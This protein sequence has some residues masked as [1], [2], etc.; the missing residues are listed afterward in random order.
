M[1][2]RVPLF[3]LE[4]D[5]RER[6][7]VN[8]VLDSKWLTM[9]DETTAFER[10]FAQFTGAQHA[11]AVANC[12]AALHLAVR[13][14]DLEPG[15]EVIVPSL[16]FAAT[17]HCV[18]YEGGTPVFADV[19]SDNDLTISP[20]DI[21]R[22]I[23]D[24]TRAIIPMHY[25]GFPCD[26]D[27]IG[28]IATRNGLQV[29][30]DA[31][32]SPGALHEGRMTGTIGR[33]GC[34]SF[35]SNKNLST[36]EGGMLVTDDAEVAARARLLR[37]HG[38]TAAARDR[39]NRHA[40]GYDIAETGFNYRL[41]EIEAA[42]GRV[43]LAKLER[44]NEVRSELVSR[45]RERLADIDGLVVPFA[46]FGTSAWGYSATSAHHIMVVLLPE[47]A[48]RAAVVP[49]LHDA[50]I[51][52]SVH[53]RPLH[54]FSSAEL[55]QAPGRELPV[56]DAIAS[57]LLTLPLWPGMGADGVDLACLE[58]AVAVDAVRAAGA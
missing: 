23:T 1:E 9:G 17:A 6:E 43:Q 16:T 31:A 49:R 58:L 53:Y 24:K 7:A 36:G 47:D 21:E 56:L 20:A 52:T 8:R 55:A 41:T 5:D 4:Y 11:V 15:D 2:W 12:T 45:Y 42:L 38:M 50:G 46:G 39:H 18:L 29:I 35:Y 34:F 57:R 33:A 32:H 54:T 14:L 3:D 22:K 30:E 19:V 10:E 48:E 27:A 28:E 13:S 44:G 51:G 37:C 26:M 40:W 25:G